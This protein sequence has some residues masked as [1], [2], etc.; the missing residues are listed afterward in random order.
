MSHP[1]QELRAELLGVVE[2]LEQ[3]AIYI[4]S[5]DEGKARMQQARKLLQKIDAIEGSLLMMG[6][7]GG[8][9]VA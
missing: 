3:N 6:L 8:T 9:G 7:L 1:I 2:L 5:A 4:L